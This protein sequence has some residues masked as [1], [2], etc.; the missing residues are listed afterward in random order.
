[1]RENLRPVVVALLC[2]LAIGLAAATLTSPVDPGDSGDGTAV[3]GSDDGS[4][5]T[6]DIESVGEA[7][8]QNSTGQSGGGINFDYCW[9]P[10]EGQPVWLVALAGILAA[11]MAVTIVYDRYAGLLAAVI[12]LWPVLILTLVLT[13]GCQT[14]APTEEAVRGAANATGDAV[15][16][17]PGTGDDRTF[18]SPVSLIALLLVVATLGVVT[19]MFLRNGG[20]D[21]DPAVEQSADEAETRARIGSVA[22]ETADRIE[23]DAT[24]ENEVYRAWAEMAE[25]LPVEQPETSTPAEF[26]DAAIDAGISPDDVRELTDIFESVRYGTADPTAEREQRA[27][28]ALRRIERNYSAGD[29]GSSAPGGGR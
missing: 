11:G 3:T 29:A 21:T 25:P 14:P 6:P 19:A 27:V 18:T 2:V 24:L 1:M 16:A 5:G 13:A 7:G 22:G 15:S 10:V 4:T 12:A 8:I 26:A 9:K 20:T 28:D 23:G 17:A